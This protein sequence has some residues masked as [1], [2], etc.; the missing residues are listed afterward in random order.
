MDSIFKRLLRMANIHIYENK[1]I[2]IHD[3]RR[4]MLTTMI[5]KCKIDSVLADTCLSHKQ[6]GVIEH[7]L[8]FKY[9]DVAKAYKKFWKKVRKPLNK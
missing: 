6:R 9:K 4:M 1:T 8:S 5:T 2:S 3:L 7:Y